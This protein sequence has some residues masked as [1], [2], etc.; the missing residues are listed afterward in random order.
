MFCLVAS[1]I[2]VVEK[3][4]LNTYSDSGEYQF[5]EGHLYFGPIRPTEV[6]CLVTRGS[7]V[8]MVL[9]ADRF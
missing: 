2:R 5:N 1:N 3:A 6:A 8:V 7:K 9:E 4:C